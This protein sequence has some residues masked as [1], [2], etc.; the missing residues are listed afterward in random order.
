M[1]NNNMD[2]ANAQEAMNLFAEGLTAAQGGNWEDNYN[3][4]KN[5]R[6]QWDGKSSYD[7]MDAITRKGYYQDY[8]LNVQGNLGKTSYYVGM[9]YL[10]TEGLV[11]GSDMERFSG[12]INLE[13]KF[14][15]ARIGVNSSYSYSTQNGFSLSTNGSMQTKATSITRKKPALPLTS[16]ICTIPMQI[17]TICP[18]HSAVT[19]HLHSAA[20]TVGAISGR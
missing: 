5:N 4:L 2:F 6:F 12:R 10:N 19:A 7:W 11:I 20:T 18:A 16:A 9:G 1:G 3:N 13:S 17:N 15:W 14:N 8:N